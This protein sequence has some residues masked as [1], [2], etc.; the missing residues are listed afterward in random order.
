VIPYHP[1]DV[2]I[3][4]ADGVESAND[5]S[6]NFVYVIKTGIR[7]T[8]LNSGNLYA[9]LFLPVAPF[10]FA[11]KN[12]LGLGEFVGLLLKQPG[13]DNVLSVGECSQS[14][15]A[16]IN[17]YLLSS[18]GKFVYFFIKNQ[19]Y[20]VFLV[21]ALGYRYSGWYTC[22][23]SRP[24]NIKAS[25]FGKDKVSIGSVPFERAVCIFSRLISFLFLE[26]GIACSFIKKVMECGL[27]VS[28]C[29][30]CRNTRN[31]VQPFSFRLFLQISQSGRRS[32][33]IDALTIMISISS[34]SKSPIVDES[35]GTKGSCQKLFLVFRGIEPKFISHL[36]NFKYSCV[37]LKSQQERRA[38]ILLSPEADSLLAA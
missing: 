2:Q 32:V 35:T 34:C 36:H 10:Y 25:D 3:F 37:R 26:G 21:T 29:L 24:V 33:I 17:S 27:K 14:V 28:K 31:F 9:L 1:T 4:N 23:S 30:L 38:A 16:K 19:S 8:R 7:N 22:K 13:V 5:I 20:E 15:Q 12:A 18:F 6:C 11:G